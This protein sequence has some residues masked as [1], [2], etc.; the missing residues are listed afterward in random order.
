MTKSYSYTNNEERTA[1]CLKKFNGETVL[2]FLIN[3]K[4]PIIFDVGA[5]NGKSLKEFKE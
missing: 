4:K 3:S 1:E 2:K 5:N